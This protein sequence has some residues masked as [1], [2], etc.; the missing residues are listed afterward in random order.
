MRFKFLVLALVFNTIVIAQTAYWQ[1][2]V[3]YEMEIDF[4]TSKH[5]YAGKQK[6]TYFNNSPDTLN[7]VFYHF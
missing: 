2:K 3:N 5:Q 7:K 1:Q 6:L 4:D